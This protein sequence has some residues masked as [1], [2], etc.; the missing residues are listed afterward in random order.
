MIKDDKR[1]TSLDIEL[2]DYLIFKFSEPQNFKAIV[3]RVDN[4]DY[5]FS[6]RIDWTTDRKIYAIIDDEFLEYMEKT[7][8]L[9]ISF[10]REVGD[11]YIV[12]VGTNLYT[13]GIIM[14]YKGYDKNV[15]SW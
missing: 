13:R 6:P 3:V 14:L 8:P 12:G 2:G 1:G 10:V 11:P 7:L 9:T 5:Q 4:I 15:F